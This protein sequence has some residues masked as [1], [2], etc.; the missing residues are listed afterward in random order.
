MPQS[1][2]LRIPLAGP[3]SGLLRPGPLWL[4]A[5][6]VAAAF[7]FHSGLA[8]LGAAWATPEYSHGPVV[9]LVSLFLFLR[10]MRDVPPTAAPVTD[11]WPGLVL[12]AVALALGFIGNATRIDDITT[13]GF[14]LWVGGVVLVSFGLRRGFAFWPSVL[15]LIFMLPLPQF[16]YWKVSVALQLVSSQIGVAMIQLA[17]MPVYLDG[18]IID[19]GIYKLQ[20]AEACSG[21]SYLFPMLSFSYTFAVLYKGPVWHKLLLLGMAGPI[22]VAMN[23]FRIGVIGIMVRTHGISYAE[24]FL[25]F[26]EGWVIFVACMAILIALAWTLQRL[27]RAPLPLR[28]ALDID[29]DGAGEQFARI[30]QV[31]FTRAMAVAA[32]VTALAATSH[33]FPERSSI[34][35]ARDILVTVPQVID[36]RS[37]QWLSLDREIER[38]LGADDYVSALYHDPQGGPTVDL[39]AAWYAS[40]T[41]GEGIHSPEVCL[42]VGGWEVSAWRQQTIAIDGIAPFEVNRAVIQKGTSRQLVY[43]WFEQRGRR[44]ASDYDVKVRAVLDEMLH[45]RSDGGLVRLITPIG[46]R[47]ADAAADARLEA[48]MADLLPSM[49]RFFPE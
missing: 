31:P 27:T 26:F 19:L 37:A 3:L 32:V 22:T 25:H 34:V 11:R 5:A 36:G 24:G 7:Y 15:H 33:L 46:A 9:P 6:F 48:F 16:V 40:Q 41:A 45:G 10:E 29:F 42:P 17:G 21:L 14:V 12:I 49:P 2:I 18:N 47:E 38:V 39:F 28:E 43:F 44:I 23:A 30:A 35:P 20:V 1:D 8:S 4:L 13:Y